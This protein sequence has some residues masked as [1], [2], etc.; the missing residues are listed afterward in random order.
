[1]KLR[2]YFT[3]FTKIGQYITGKTFSSQMSLDFCCVK[4]WLFLPA[5]YQQF[6]LLVERE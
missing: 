3:R 4:A 5:L 1:M 6:R 2:L